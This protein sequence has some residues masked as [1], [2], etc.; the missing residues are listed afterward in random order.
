MDKIEEKMKEMMKDLAKEVSEETSLKIVGSSYYRWDSQTSY[1]PTLTFLFKETGV[2]N[3]PRQTQ[4]QA[5]LEIRGTDLWEQN[6]DRLKQQI[7]QQLP[8]D[9]RRLQEITGDYRRL[10][11]IT[12]DY[13]RLQEITGDY[14]HG[15]VRGNYVS[16]RKDL[17]TTIFGDSRDDVVQVLK[18]VCIIVAEDFQ[19]ANLSNL[20]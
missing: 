12:G 5:R 9:Y 10:Q 14:R 7:S 8:I 19:L 16:K 6:T 2:S 11:E 13:R 18:K 20:S 15:F 3:Y 1:Y 4:I 17:K